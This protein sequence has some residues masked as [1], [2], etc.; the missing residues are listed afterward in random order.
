[1]DILELFEEFLDV[2]MEK[3]GN[4]P[5]TRKTYKSKIGV[6]YDFV[7]SKLREINVNYIYFLNTADKEVLLQSVEYYIKAGN[8]KSR[9]TVDVYYSVIGN[10][11]S[12]LFDKYGKTNDYF[13]TVEKRAEFKEAY[14]RKIREL[15]LLESDQQE[16]IKEELAKDIL[17]ECDKIIDGVDSE[18]LLKKKKGIYS[19]YISALIVKFVLLYGLKNDAIRK[20]KIKDYNDS[21]NN[22]IIN[23]YRIRLPDR[24]AMQMKKYKELR[25]EFLE[26]YS[27]ESER[28]FFDDF[29]V[30]KELD[31]TK[32]FIVLKK[33]TGNMQ[34]GAVAKYAIMELLRE[35]VPAYIISNFT[36]YKG[37]VLD[38]CQERIDEDRGL[39]SLKEKSRI[40]DSALRRRGLFDDM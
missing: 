38:Y 4:D 22:L 18:G 35:G 19:N 36:D 15:N 6:F 26:R 1:M 20:L 10:F 31:N 5:G 21:L 24:L 8:V 32:M 3:I 27:L 7:L 39:F 14:E 37:E 33:T 29:N 16:P 40:L 13:Q 28:L 12:F 9:A 34:A 23:H 17:K 11:Y 2:L 25:K 30:D